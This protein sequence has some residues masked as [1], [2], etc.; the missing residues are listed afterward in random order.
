MITTRFVQ[1]YIQ[2]MW[3]HCDVE[4]HVR[5]TSGAI[6]SG[7]HTEAGVIAFCYEN[8]PVQVYDS[9]HIGELIGNGSSIDEALMRLNHECHKALISALGIDCEDDEQMLQLSDDYPEPDV[10]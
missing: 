3:E 9:V 2:H 10:G 4:L 1:G 8:D 6:E 5:I 7:M